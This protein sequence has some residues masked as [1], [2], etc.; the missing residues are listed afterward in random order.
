MEAGAVG[1]AAAYPMARAASHMLEKHGPGFQRAA[2]HMLDRG[3]QD[4]SR[5]SSNM[6]Q[7]GLHAHAYYTLHPVSRCAS[8]SHVFCSTSPC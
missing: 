1:A 5:A 7:V 6:A 3:K 2:S 8:V 4:F